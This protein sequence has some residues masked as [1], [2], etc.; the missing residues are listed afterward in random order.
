[1]REECADDTYS[2]SAISISWPSSFYLA[3]YTGAADAQLAFSHPCF[4]S[5][6]FYVPPVLTLAANLLIPKELTG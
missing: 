6:L 2:L 1:M 5:N 4:G 3:L